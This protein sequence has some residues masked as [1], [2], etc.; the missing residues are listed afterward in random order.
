MAISVNAARVEPDLHAKCLR[1]QQVSEAHQ[2]AQPLPLAWWDTSQETMSIK[3]QLGSIRD[4]LMIGLRASARTST[5]NLQAEKVFQACLDL[6]ETLARRPAE[7]AVTDVDL[8]LS[9]MHKAVTEL[10][11]ETAATKAVVSS[12]QNAIGRLQG[13]RAEL[14]VK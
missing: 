10:N 1:P 2:P 6:V 5:R 8:T 12:M 3:S 4:F 13:L 11:D 9:L 14:A 7:I